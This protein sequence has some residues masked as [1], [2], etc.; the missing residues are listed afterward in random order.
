MSDGD[1][2]G[3]AIEGAGLRKAYGG[4]LALD[5]ATFSAAPGE[6]HALVGENGAG[7][8]TMIKSLAGV[9]RPDDGQVLLGGDEVRLRSP[10]DALRRGV[11]TVFQEL[12]LLPQYDRGREPAD[13]TRAT[14]QPWTDPPPGSAWRGRRP[15]RGARRRLGRRRRAHRE[16]ASGATAARSRSSAP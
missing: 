2:N 14:R 7:K 1:R 11:A 13:G 9:I 5:D 6:V 3:N 16:P 4:V 8:S 10:E 15:A 12:T